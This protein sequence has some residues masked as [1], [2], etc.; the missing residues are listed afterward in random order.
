MLTICIEITMLCQEIAMKEIAQAH[1]TKSRD[2]SQISFVFITG[3]YARRKI[4]RRVSSS[5]IYRMNEGR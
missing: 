5:E 4:G 2:Q 3:P 1:K